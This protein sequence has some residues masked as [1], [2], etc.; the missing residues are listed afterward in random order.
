M[1]GKDEV[2]AK[3]I[4]GANTNAIESSNFIMIAMMD[5]RLFSPNS[6]RYD[7]CAMA[8]CL[9]LNEGGFSGL[10]SALLTALGIPPTPFQEERLAKLE[11][12][13]LLKRKQKLRFPKRKPRNKKLRRMQAKKY[14]GL[15][16]GE[17]GKK[18][19][20]GRAPRRCG[21]CKLVG[22]DRRNCQAYKDK[23]AEVNLAEVTA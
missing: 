5:K 8:V 22:H 11:Q 2:I 6:V 20:A 3:Y 7:I 21:F 10:Y 9:F 1:H 18:P 19:H 13:R 12:G 4:T 17:Y 23:L 16:L 15:D 14:K